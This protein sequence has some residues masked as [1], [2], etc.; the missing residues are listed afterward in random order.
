MEGD[1]KNL[2][3]LSMLLGNL[4]S[5]LTSKSR[6]QLTP[7]ILHYLS[8]SF[9]PIIVAYLILVSVICNQGSPSELSSNVLNA[10]RAQRCTWQW[11]WRKAVRMER[12]RRCC[13]LPHQRFC[14]KQSPMV[15][16]GGGNCKVSGDWEI[17]F[18]SSPWVG[19]PPEVIRQEE[20]HSWDGV[21]ILNHFNLCFKDWSFSLLI[22]FITVISTLYL[23]KKIQAQGFY[24][25]PI[26]TVSLRLEEAVGREKICCFFTA[27]LVQFS[28]CQ[29]ERDGTVVESTH[30]QLSVLAHGLRAGPW[31]S[32]HW[33]P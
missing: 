5:G 4:T 6:G 10:V 14:S 3:T 28:G 18:F 20:L 13:Q 15:W 25:L 2:I 12:E 19:C 23:G 21:L 30:I 9:H 8:Q 17:N 1:G 24:E 27:H 7:G 32:W 31:A 16:G 11:W 29:Y 26:L 22:C 33:H